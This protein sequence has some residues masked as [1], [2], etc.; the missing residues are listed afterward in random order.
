M[1]RR[2]N[3]RYSMVVE[4]SLENDSTV[5]MASVGFIDINGHNISVIGKDEDD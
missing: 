5:E 4:T 3:N 2:T 1:E